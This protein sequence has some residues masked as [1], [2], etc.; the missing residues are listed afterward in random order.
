MRVKYED[1]ITTYKYPQ[2]QIMPKRANLL[3]PKFA[4]PNAKPAKPA[5]RA[6]RAKPRGNHQRRQG[7]SQADVGPRHP[8][9]ETK[10]VTHP[11][12]S[13]PTR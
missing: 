4:I 1:N 5:K 12:S 6:K 2:Q 11:P 9:S 8:E 7:S 10:T 13:Q 3:K